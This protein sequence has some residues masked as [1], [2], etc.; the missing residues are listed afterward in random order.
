MKPLALL[1]LAS[2]CAC[3]GPGSFNGQVANNPLGVR[4]AVFSVAKDNKGNPLYAL[5]ILSDVADSCATLKANRNP[6]TATYLAI[7]LYRFSSSGILAPDVAEYGVAASLPLL[8]SGNWASGTFTRNDP[9][10]TNTIA[11]KSAVTK[12]GLLK[13]QA[14]KAGPGG[15][16]GGNFD[17]TFG[18][19]ADKASGAFSAS[20]CDWD[21]G[22]FGQLHCE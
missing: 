12:S 16:L 17:L 19:Q 7:T 2:L 11:A 13:V 1:A 5:L 4:D 21:P 10:C 14:Y 6:K 18:D 15:V 3:G 22:T 9:N 20:F 8:T